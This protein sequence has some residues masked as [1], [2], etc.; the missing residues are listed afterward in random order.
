MDGFTEKEMA[1]IIEKCGGVKE[2]LAGFA[3]FKRDTDYF[4]AHFPE[5]LDKYPNKWV[6]VHGAKVVGTGKD[7][8][9]LL[10]RLKKKGI[11]TNETVIHFLNPNPKP[12]I[13]LQIG[14]TSVAPI[15]L[16]F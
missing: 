6:A 8:S 11:P 14:A 1:E 7:L 9:R 2:I 3:R 15:S 12:L 5:L 16:T 13:L 10:G 4:E